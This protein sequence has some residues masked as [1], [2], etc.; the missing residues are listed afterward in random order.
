MV[1]RLG[2]VAVGPPPAAEPAGRWRL[3]VKGGSQATRGGGSGVKRQGN[4]RIYRNAQSLVLPLRFGPS[5]EWERGWRSPPPI[6]AGLAGRTAG[7]VRTSFR[8]TSRK[9]VL[10]A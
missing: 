10:N 1:T 9:G 7:M 3:R 6:R 2:V 5:R 4:F 8:L